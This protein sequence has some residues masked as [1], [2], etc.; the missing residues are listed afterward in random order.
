MTCSFYGER[1]IFFC[2]LLLHSNNTTI[3][4]SMAVLLNVREVGPRREFHY[5]WILK[6]YLLDVM[7]TSELMRD[8]FNNVVS[9]RAVT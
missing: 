5:I 7:Y 3:N 6:I 4:G 8:R 9:T 2:P 1:N